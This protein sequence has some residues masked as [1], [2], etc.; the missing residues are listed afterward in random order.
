MLTQRIQIKPG[1]IGSSTQPRQHLPT[2]SGAH[3]HSTLNQRACSQGSFAL[4]L[5]G[6]FHALGAGTQ[7]ARCAQL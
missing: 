3:I 2:F 5:S 7:F 6:L 1:P 4:D